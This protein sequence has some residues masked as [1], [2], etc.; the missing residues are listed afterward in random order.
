MKIV[1]Y[2]S[3]VTVF[4]VFQT[5]HG[6]CI[7]KTTFDN[8]NNGRETKQRSSAAAEIT[9]SLANNE[10]VTDARAIATTGISV[11]TLTTTTTKTKVTTRTTNKKSIDLIQGIN[12]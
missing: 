7:Q 9:T 3:I 2:L 6:V 1:K 12:F 4:V 11:E 5:T 8:A 10:I